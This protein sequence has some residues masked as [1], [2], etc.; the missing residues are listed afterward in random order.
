MVEILFSR[1]SVALHN[2]ETNSLHLEGFE[3]DVRMSFL[4]NSGSV[5][6]RDQESNT[7]WRALAVAFKALGSL[8]SDIILWA[9]TE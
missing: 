8:G 6:R 4:K 1:D 3:S 2:R 7:E 5:G 9:P